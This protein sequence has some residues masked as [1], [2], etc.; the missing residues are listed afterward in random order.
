[1]TRPNLTIVR[2]SLYGVFAALGA[3][4]CAALVMPAA[5]AAPADDCSGAGLAGV[6][7]SVTQAT[8]DYLA[9]HPD[10]NQALLDITRQPVFTASGQ[11]DDYFNNHPTEADELRAIQQPALAYQNR[12]GMQVEPSQ[13]FMVLQAL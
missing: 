12:C 9:A 5:G 8:S 4:S 3:A 6:I 11:F 7:S 13:A 1:M 2:R 10:T